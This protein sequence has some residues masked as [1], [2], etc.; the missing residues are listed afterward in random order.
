MQ[1][2]YKEKK[3]KMEFPNR[4]PS[5]YS[6]FILAGQLMRFTEHDEIPTKAKVILFPNEKYYS[7]AGSLL[8]EYW[9]L[10]RYRT[11]K[12]K[13]NE[14][15]QQIQNA[16]EKALAEEDGFLFNAKQQMADSLKRIQSIKDLERKIRTFQNSIPMVTI[17]IKNGF[18][19]K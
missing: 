8:P 1:F 17:E 9:A 16:I 6:L 14:Q 2:I 15:I 13:M 10:E 3:N 18:D 12:P 4:H 19:S 7:P 11:E 5:S